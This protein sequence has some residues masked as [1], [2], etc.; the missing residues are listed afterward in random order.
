MNSIKIVFENKDFLVCVKPP[1]IC[2]DESD[3]GIVKAIRATKNDASFPLYIV[4]RLDKMVGGLMVLAKNQN[5]ASVLSKAIADRQFEKEYLAIIEGKMEEKNGKLEDLLFRDVRKNKTYVVYRERKGV[6]KAALLFDV[7]SEKEDISLVKVHLLTGRTHQIRV[8][9]A[10]R[11]HPL[12][13]DR[14]YGA[15]NSETAIALWSYRLHFYDFDFC[16]NPPGNEPW[17]QFEEGIV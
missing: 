7:L 17:N 13:G 10:S 8:Q 14:R 16:E 4:H 6:R 15:K 11:K 12:L 3:N 9:F 5:W 2:S 1:E